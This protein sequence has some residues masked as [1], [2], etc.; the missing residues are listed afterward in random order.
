MR[1]EHHRRQVIVPSHRVSPRARRARRRCC[2]WRRWSPRGRARRH[3]L[4][5][6]VSPARSWSLSASRQLPP[7][8]SAPMRLKVSSL[9]SR[10]S[11]LMWGVMRQANLGTARPRGCAAGAGASSSSSS[12][13][14]ARP[15]RSLA[16]AVAASSDAS[17]AGRVMS[18]TLLIDRAAVRPSGKGNVKDFPLVSQSSALL[19][20]VHIPEPRI[21]VPRYG[22]QGTPIQ[23]EAKSIPHRDASARTFPC[24]WPHPRAGPCH[25]RP[26]S[27]CCAPAG[28][29]DTSDLSLVFEHSALVARDR[30]PEPDGAVS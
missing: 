24:E 11:R 20:G 12:V 26:R 19:S 27:Q 6:Q 22:G 2:R 28:E 9:P 4:H 16:R 8:G 14:S 1:A 15:T 18:H 17:V 3:P 7:P 21:A 29:D 13:S 5:E 25:R 30:I 10:R 23:R